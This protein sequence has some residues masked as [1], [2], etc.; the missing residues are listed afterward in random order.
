[1]HHNLE[2]LPVTP[3]S[4]QWAVL[5]VLFQYVWENPSEY[6]ELNQYIG[7]TTGLDKQNF[8]A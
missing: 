2:N 6:N 8:S 5:Y 1:M 7:L 3:K 4:T